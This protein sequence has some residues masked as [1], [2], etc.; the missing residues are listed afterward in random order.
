MLPDDGTHESFATSDH[1]YRSRFDGDNSRPF[2]SR[3]SSAAAIDCLR[4]LCR[5][6]GVAASAARRAIFS[7]AA[8]AS[9]LHVFDRLH[10]QLF[11]GATNLMIGLRDRLGVE[12]AAEPEKHRVVAAALE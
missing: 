7:G 9:R 11:H 12:I 3:R 2:I 8:S 6:A 1:R 5:T 4:H 10:R